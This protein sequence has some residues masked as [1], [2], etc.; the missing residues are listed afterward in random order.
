MN[1][2]T[3]SLASAKVHGVALADMVGPNRSHKFSPA[4]QAVAVI[5]RELDF[6]LSATARALGR[7]YCT[8]ASALLDQYDTY[9]DEAR[10]GQ[11]DAV[12]TV[13]IAHLQARAKPNTPTH[14]ATA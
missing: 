11:V 10:I 4:R 6:S 12:R 13:A 8:T 7:K 5:A 1:L 14:G 9:A 3:V 2:A